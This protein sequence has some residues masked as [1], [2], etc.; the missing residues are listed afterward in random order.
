MTGAAS[1]PP[2]HQPGAPQPWH[3]GPRAGPGRHWV[4][5]GL[6]YRGADWLRAELGLGLRASDS[7][8]RPKAP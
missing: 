7:W 6:F 8:A 1:H 4:P 3:H 5:D 2:G